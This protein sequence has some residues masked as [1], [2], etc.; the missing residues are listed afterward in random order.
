LPARRPL[1]EAQTNEQLQNLYNSYSRIWMVLWASQQADPQGYV[2]RWL[3]SHAYK[4]QSRWFGG[5]RLAL[6]AIPGASDNFTE[7]SESLSN[8]ITLI[9]QSLENET[10]RPGDTLGITLRW[11][12]DKTLD[13]RYKV[14]AQLLNANGVLWAQHDSEPAGGS[15]PTVVWKPGEVIEDRHGIDLPLGSPPG[16][17]LVIA[18]IYEPDTGQRVTLASASNQDHLTIGNITVERP[19]TAI[20]N[21]ENMVLPIKIHRNLSNEIRLLGGEIYEADAAGRNLKAGAAAHLVLFWQATQA[22]LSNYR[23]KIEMSSGQTFSNIWE[24]YPAG[25]GYPTDQWQPGELVR[26]LHR[27]E[28][29]P[30]GSYII[31]VSLFSEKSHINSISIPDI[32][33]K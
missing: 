9:G 28:I 25:P 1:D 31:T 20:P 7:R 16:K 11:R 5:V 27:L 30:P 3:D 32:Q 4:S 23:L 33:V 17:Y 12:T 8:G 21:F 18:G 24:G 10:A 19:D 13:R 2:E 22:P 6:Y 29:G 15:K 14:F 26:T